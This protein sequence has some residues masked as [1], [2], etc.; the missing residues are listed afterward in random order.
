MFLAG[1]LLTASYHTCSEKRGHRAVFFFGKLVLQMCLKIR[2]NEL[3]N[4]D[5]EKKEETNTVNYD[6]AMVKSAKGGDKICNVRQL[7]N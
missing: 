1:R 6:A 2:T 3:S 5:S 7:A 4:R